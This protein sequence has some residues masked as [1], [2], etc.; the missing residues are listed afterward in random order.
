MQQKK[1]SYNPML[2]SQDRRL[3]IVGRERHG[4]LCPKTGV[5]IVTAIVVHQICN[6]RQQIQAP[7]AVFWTSEGTAYTLLCL[8][9]LVD[10]KSIDIP[11]IMC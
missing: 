4:G 3:A 1:G 6:D 5:Y 7:G 9:R 11:I 8:F 10:A 2:R